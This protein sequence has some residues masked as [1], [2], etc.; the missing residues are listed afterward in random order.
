MRVWF[1]LCHGVRDKLSALHGVDDEQE[2]ANAFAAI[3]P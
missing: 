2:V 3:L 1:A